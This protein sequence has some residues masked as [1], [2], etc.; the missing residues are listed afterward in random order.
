MTPGQRARMQ[1]LLGAAVKRGLFPS[2]APGAHGAH[3]AHGAAGAAAPAAASPA[4]ATG[5]ADRLVRFRAELTALAGT[6]HEADGVEAIADLVAEL[7]R[8]EG[9]PRVIAWSEGALGVPGLHASIAARGLEIVPPDVDHDGRSRQEQLDRLASAS[10]GVTGADVILADTGSIVVLSGPGRPR[11]ASLL[12]P[13]HVA[14]VHPDRIVGSI[15]E[16]L[17]TRPEL[18]SAGSNL[19]A[20]TGP[21]RTADIEHT[22]SR[23]VHGPREVHAVVCRFAAAAGPGE[24]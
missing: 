2:S 22:L 10:V 6:V 18:V 23:G 15:S 7:A 9:S 3:G 21:S 17:A 20:I 14:L 1:E 19:V 11:L 8:A 5:E 13:V 24:P 4:R 16:L 12:T